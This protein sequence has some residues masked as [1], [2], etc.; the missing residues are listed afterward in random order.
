ME[1]AAGLNHR[2]K[3]KFDE[4]F[5]AFDVKIWDSWDHYRIYAMIQEDEIACE[6]EKAEMDWMEGKDR[7]A[8][9]LNSRNMQMP[10]AKWRI[11]RKTKENFAKQTPENVRIR[12]EAAARRIKVTKRGVLEKQA[13]KARAGHL[14]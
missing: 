10:L 11:V 14:V 12:E 9:K 5:F 3:R 7:R 13:R 8:K 6:K 4:A 2:P 1:G